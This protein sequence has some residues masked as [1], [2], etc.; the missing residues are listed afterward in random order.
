[1]KSVRKTVYRE[2]ALLVSVVPPSQHLNPDETPGLIEL[3][4]LANTA[5][6]I[7]VDKIIQKKDKPEVTFYIGRG[8][9]AEIKELVVEHEIDVVIF[10]NNLSPGQTRNLEKEIQAKVID[11]T[12]LILDIFATHARSRQAK[13]QVELAQL[14]YTLP[15]L[16]RMW[17]HLSRIE[18]GIGIGQRG[19]GEQQI[20]ID[21]RLA[22]DRITKIKREIKEINERRQR[23]IET[24]SEYFNISLI[25]YTNAGKSTLMNTLTGTD[26]FVEDKLFSTLDTKT[27]LWHIGKYKVLLS[28]TVGFI[29][30]LPHNLVASFHATLQ[31]TISADLL[32]H[33]VDVSHQNVSDHIEAVNKVLNELD[34]GEKR[35]L[36]VF[37]KIDHA[38]PLDI[39]IIIKEFPDAVLISARE[40]T[41][42][43][44]LAKL[45]IKIREENEIEATFSIPAGDGKLRAYLAEHGQIIKESYTDSKVRIKMKLTPQAHAR[46][47]H[48]L[49]EVRK[50]GNLMV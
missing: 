6:A 34:C 15:R 29:K 3:E 32:L 24:R 28:D 49:K 38:D 1:V 11:R 39:Q 13:L 42:L 12:E 4:Q 47:V 14:E 33:I 8:K 41:G 26:C 9:V 19:P 17:T 7:V 5:G 35:R 50:E 44:E 31:E 30:N 18:G 46:V 16:K 21:R 45:I 43:G 25:G 40:K 36:L 2:H 20:E 48:H 22:R 10:D 37:N 27:N 23:D